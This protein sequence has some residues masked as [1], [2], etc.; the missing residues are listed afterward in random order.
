MDQQ[1]GDMYKCLPRFNRY[2]WGSIHLRTLVMI[3]I[4]GCCL[5]SCAGID[6][7]PKETTIKCIDLTK[8]SEKGFLITPGEY[9]EDYVSLGMFSFSVFPKAEKVTVDGVDSGF[10]AYPRGGE[11]KESSKRYSSIWV[12]GLSNQN[13]HQGPMDHLENFT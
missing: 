2:L 6:H 1:C 13:P 12:C 9:G 4:V 10:A 3:I 5:T 8:Y 11:Y 7:I